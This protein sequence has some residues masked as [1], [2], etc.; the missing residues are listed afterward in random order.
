ML[1][2]GLTMETLV[3]KKLHL[4]N[5][6]NFEDC[7]ITFNQK[8]NQP[9]VII[10][11]TQTGKSNIIYA[12]RI[13]LDDMLS[14][15]YSPLE[16][17]DFYDH[18]EALQISL[19]LQCPLSH[20]LS[21]SL[22]EASIT[23]VK[24]NDESPTFSIR[25]GLKAKFENED[26]Q[27]GFFTG[28][29]DSSNTTFNRRRYPEIKEYLKLGYLDAL[30]DV[31]SE[32]THKK[33]TPLLYAI[34]KLAHS[35]GRSSPEA[36]IFN[37]LNTQITSH[38]SELDQ[39]KE[40]VKTIVSKHNINTG[41]R[42]KQKYV[43]ALQPRQFNDYLGEMSLRFLS[44]SD[45]HLDLEKASLGINNVLYLTLKTLLYT[46]KN[47]KKTK[48]LSSD[49]ADIIPFT[50]L[51]I[52]EPEAH[53]HPQLQRQVYNT[54]KS[55]TPDFG[56]IFT[57]HSPHLVSVTDFENLV[58]LR[59]EANGSSQAY[60]LN[61]NKYTEDEWYKL[62]SYLHVSRSEMLFASGVILVEGISEK[63]LIS[64]WYPDLDGLGISIGVIDGTDFKIYARCLKQLNI[65]FCV[66][67]DF[68]P[69]E[70]NENRSTNK[71]V[72]DFGNCPQVFHN[73][74]TF[75]YELF[76]LNNRENTY[77]EKFKALIQ[78][79]H[80][81]IYSEHKGTNSTFDQLFVKA[82]F[83]EQFA[84]YSKFRKGVFAQEIAFEI[85]NKSNGAVDSDTKYPIPTYITDAV[86]YISN[87][88]APAT[89][90]KPLVTA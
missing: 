81:K 47:F 14:L 44:R 35:Y 28:N 46:D 60:N 69:D 34:K 70:I 17:S 83:K 53:L 73:K 66:I 59:K 85:L 18:K 84:R 54:L 10:G 57:T 9:I 45:K 26:L 74:V 52:E 58:L 89:L 4:I 29:P 22:F 20:E 87:E 49:Q 67:T 21:P 31:Q 90:E 30:R 63:H 38:I 86:S 82:N 72:K 25:L 36:S 71:F 23:Q 19:E 13:L 51:A 78:S 43:L 27:F 6:R 12:L 75:E 37:N 61:K 64:A 76:S 42:H 16:E 68:D 62:K 39:I 15:D 56:C 2:R 80:P 5:F 48:L 77:F 40:V 50:W 55:N 7:T 79:I 11:E 88:V 3:L 41:E 8:P 24:D 1:L 65:P 32:L 33:K